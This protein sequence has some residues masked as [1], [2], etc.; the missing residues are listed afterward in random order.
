MEN[1]FKIEQYNNQSNIVYISSMVLSTMMVLILYF[2]VG[3]TFAAVINL[4][5]VG[6]AGVAV[7][8]NHKKH[9]GLGALIFI[10]YISVIAVLQGILF[11]LN[12][13]FQYF[14]FNMAGLIMYSSFWVS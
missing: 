8:L 11:G 12:S 5:G 6:L 10:G 2:V 13:G 14:F 4:I 9:Y 3:S 1:Q 7:Y